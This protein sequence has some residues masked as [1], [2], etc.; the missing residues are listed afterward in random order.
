M[1]SMVGEDN[2][3]REMN[4]KL[5]AWE[6]QYYAKRDH[7]YTYLEDGEYNDKKRLNDVVH[8]HSACE[9]AVNKHTKQFLGT[10]LYT[11]LVGILT[12]ILEINNTYRHFHVRHVGSLMC[13]DSEL[14]NVKHAIFDWVKRYCEE[15]VKKYNSKD[16]NDAVI[17]FR[18][19]TYEGHNLL[20]DIIHQVHS[21]NIVVMDH[22]HHYVVWKLYCLTVGQEVQIQLLENN[23]L[24][25]DINASL[26]Y[27]T[28]LIVD[29]YRQA[30]W[31]IC[32][33][34]RHT[35]TR[36]NCEGLVSTKVRQM[37]IHDK[38]YELQF[39][40]TNIL[41]SKPFLIRNYKPEKMKIQMGTNTVTW[42]WY[43]SDIIGAISFYNSNTEAHCMTIKG[44]C[45]LSLGLQY[46]GVLTL[47]DMP[48]I[49]T[50]RLPFVL[51]FDPIDINLMIVRKIHDGLMSIYDKVDVQRILDSQ[52]RQHSHGADDEYDDEEFI[53]AACQDLSKNEPEGSSENQN[54]YRKRPVPQLRSSTF[55]RILE[56]LGCEVCRG[57]GSEVTVFR[58]GGMKRRIGHHKANHYISSYMIGSIL[59]QLN[60]SGEEWFAAAKRHYS[61]AYHRNQ[62]A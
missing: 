25:I 52:K 6:L 47:F 34:L 55:F 20:N 36:L 3:K 57:K 9:Y 42:D 41:E 2:D 22:L 45:R 53:A 32:D 51:D 61:A 13:I 48:W 35:L 58:V 28:D 39:L 19:M 30:Q 8:E 31:H 62:A 15:R 50:D 14:R 10:Q 12:K 54:E 60:V 21:I 38:I 7:I 43:Y 49:K 56:K 1:R 44:L 16:N 23:E 59:K 40:A 27:A 37:T 29:M 33:K 4:D 5:I 24:N 11:E 18:R 46:D 17:K 26:E